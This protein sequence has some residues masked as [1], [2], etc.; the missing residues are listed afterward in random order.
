MMTSYS[1]WFTFHCRSF[2]RRLFALSAIV[3]T[4]K[5][6]AKCVSIATTTTMTTMKAAD[7]LINQVRPATV[8][9]SIERRQLRSRAHCDGAAAA[10]AAAGDRAR[11]RAVTERRDGSPPSALPDRVQATVVIGRDPPRPDPRPSLSLD[12]EVPVAPHAPTTTLSTQ[13][14]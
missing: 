6:M 9:E 8:Q 5:S 11:R 3:P 2:C 1:L 13:R 12:R 14:D 7:K 4:G 10:A